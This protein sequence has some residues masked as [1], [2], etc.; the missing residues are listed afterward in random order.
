MVLKRLSV[1]QYS[2]YTIHALTK[3]SV[4]FREGN[5]KE[6]RIIVCLFVSMNFSFLIWLIL[7][8]SLWKNVNGEKY[9]HGR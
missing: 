4:P 6:K 1:E 8:V 9:T 7:H 3:D 5:E 2:T